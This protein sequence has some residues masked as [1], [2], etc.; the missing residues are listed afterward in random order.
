MKNLL[1]KTIAITLAFTAINQA[2][3]GQG[4]VTKQNNGQNDSGEADIFLMI[5]SFNPDT[6]RTLDFI[7]EFSNTLDDFYPNKHIILIED[8]AAR[9]FSEEAHLWKGR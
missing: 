2:C 1:L 9:N 4:Q 7:N 6:Q 8:M 5:S 3:N